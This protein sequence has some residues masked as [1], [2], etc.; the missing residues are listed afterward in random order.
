MPMTVVRYRPRSD[1]A[2]EN[3][4]LV[5]E[6]FAELAGTKPDGLRYMTFRLEDGTFVHVADV[7]A[8]ANPLFDSEAFARFQQGIG[9]RCV[10]GEG[11]N[12]QPAT[13]VGAY[14]FDVS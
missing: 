7:A 5:E 1:R 3:Q 9:E 11:P 4:K 2:D 6:V 14:G 10:E 12:P 13:L 8:D